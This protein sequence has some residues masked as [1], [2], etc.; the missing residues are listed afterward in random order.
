MGLAVWLLQKVKHGV[1]QEHAAPPPPPN[2]DGRPF[3]SALIVRNKGTLRPV[4]TRGAGQLNRDDIRRDR[5]HSP[6]IHHF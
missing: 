5:P 6:P 3:P 1:R 4:E 2:M